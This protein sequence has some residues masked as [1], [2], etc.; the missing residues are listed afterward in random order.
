MEE[1]KVAR[2]TWWAERGGWLGLVVLSRTRRAVC[3]QVG[4]VLA[5]ARTIGI[6][7]VAASVAGQ[8]RWW[9]GWLETT[10]QS[11]CSQL[12]GLSSKDSMAFEFVGISTTTP[13][14]CGGAVRA[15]VVIG[16]APEEPH[17]DTR[18]WKVSV[19]D[20]DDDLHGRQPLAL[21]R[22]QD[23]QCRAVGDCIARALQVDGCGR[24]RGPNARGCFREGLHKGVRRGLPE[25]V[26]PVSDPS[27]DAVTPGHGGGGGSGVTADLRGELS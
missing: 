13:C 20:H 4:L 10:A 22:I 8:A 6:G 1:G 5:E 26:R 9:C 16:H 18:D 12:V 14:S 25:G 7:A 27:P 11:G 17:F 15:R 3:P 24:R 19:Q 23:F 2:P 21:G